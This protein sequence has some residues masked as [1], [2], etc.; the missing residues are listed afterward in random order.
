MKLRCLCILGLLDSNQLYC[1][2]IIVLQMLE[3]SW[4]GPTVCHTF[5]KYTS[6]SEHTTVFTAK[7]TVF[8]FLTLEKAVD[9]L[10]SMSRKNIYIDI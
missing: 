6:N 1:F 9:N 2:F 8:K 4:V 7:R 10:N 5:H 3:I